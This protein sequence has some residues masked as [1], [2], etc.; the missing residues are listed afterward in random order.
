MNK[1]LQALYYES[2]CGFQILGCLLKKQNLIKDNKYNLKASDFYEDFHKG[3][4]ATINNLVEEG[5]EEVTAI[6]I[7]AY[8]L[9]TSPRFYKIIFEDNDG[10]KWIEDS[11]ENASLANFDYNYDRFK[12]MSLL[13]DMMEDGMDIKDIY[14]LEEI[15]SKVIREQSKN[16]DK[17][18]YSD[19]L[20]VYESR[21]VKLRDKYGD[22]SEGDY[23]RAGWNDEATIEKL[24]RGEVYGLMGLSGYKN[25]ATYGN[26]RTKFHLMSS[27]TGGGKSRMALGKLATLI[28]VELWDHDKQ[29]FVKNPNNPD[30]K[31]SGVYVGTEMQLDK[32]VD[33]ILWAV[34]S[35]I[36][37]SK[38]IEWNLTQEEEERLAYARDVV[39][40]SK[41]HLYDRPNYN[42]KMLEN[43][44]KKHQMTEDVY[45]LAVD[46][47][48]L[49]SGLVQ[50]AREYSGGMWTREDQLYLFI[51]KCF[52]E[53]LAIG[54][55]IYVT[56]STQ[57]NNKKNDPTAEKNEGMIRGSFALSDKVDVG[58]LLLKIDKQELELVREIL[59]KQGGWN[60]TLP[61][62]VEHIFKNRGSEYGQIRIFK[63]LNLGNSRTIDMFATNWDYELL[64][65]EQ[66]I[67]Q[68][69]E[70]TYQKEKIE[71]PVF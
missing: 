68:P 14:D 35:G 18:S 65:M 30:G 39:K 63:L 54:C 4:F 42:I 13:R 1:K 71:E 10:F 62:H 33:V 34:V 43:L 29:S 51:S 58:S 64:D 49:T 69:I 44:V 46:Y 6:E 17:S 21:I 55:N 60:Q 67:P 32:E 40:R 28:A 31:L 9:R 20:S 66:K 38:I 8:L 36:E 23:K 5:V 59:K 11:K 15:D 53:K 61:S 12:K 24:K 56:S 25:Q 16:F 70:E 22:D 2:R 47:I 57:L 7:E 45:V 3:M 27:G 48:M 41:I 26:R 50:E 19:I 52:K 37:T